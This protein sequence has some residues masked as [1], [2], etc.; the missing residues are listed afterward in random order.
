[1]LFQK[2][3]RTSTQLFTLS[4]ILNRLQLVTG[5]FFSGLLSVSSLLINLMAYS[6][7]LTAS[8]MIPEYPQKAKAWYRF[9]QFKH[10]N[11]SA[12][13]AGML[14]VLFFT[15]ALFFPVLM[16]PGCWCVA[17]SNLFWL[18]GEHHR[19]HNPPDWDTDFNKKSQH[20]YLKYVGF[21]TATGVSTALLMTVAFIFPASSVFILTLIG[22]L[23][24]FFAANAAQYWLAQYNVTPP[25]EI[26]NFF[27]SKI[28]YVSQALRQLGHNKQPQKTNSAII[29][30][31]Q[32]QVSTV[33][34]RSK[35]DPLQDE[36][37]DKYIEY[38]TVFK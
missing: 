25:T 21:M 4:L 5:T 26:E 1:M 36:I 19:Y 14:S 15:G 17:V 30:N 32:S 31:N 37:G 18:S 35:P 23:S 27:Q 6:C 33:L 9:S 2:L 7:W 38:P 12:A 29:S 20:I 34:L 3:Q 28:N 13:F 22:V 24:F 8:F 11:K 16:I 10:Q